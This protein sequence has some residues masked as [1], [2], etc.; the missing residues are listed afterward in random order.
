[1]R[2]GTDTCPWAV[3]FDSLRS[4]AWLSLASED[5]HCLLHYPGKATPGQRRCSR[6]G[7][8]AGASPGGLSSKRCPRVL[9]REREDDEERT[10]GQVVARA[11]CDSA[12]M[13]ST[14]A[15]A[16]QR[17]FRSWLPASGEEVDDR[18]C[19]EI[20]RSS[21]LDTVPAD[22]L[23]DLCLPLRAG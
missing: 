3:I 23:T 21:P 20:C 18:P 19:M 8:E 5:L 4:I 2:A 16:Y 13:R 7:P 15:E 9:R 10:D 22:L 6:A 17:L 14:T 1:M 12:V 11:A